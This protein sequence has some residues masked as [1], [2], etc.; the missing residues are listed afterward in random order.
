MQVGG[1]ALAAARRVPQRS[2]GAGLASKQGAWR[3]RRRHRASKAGKPS[4]GG[5]G[6]CVCAL[7]GVAP[8]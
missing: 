1:A 6:V 8:G 7:V 2:G 5:P 4:G 3:R